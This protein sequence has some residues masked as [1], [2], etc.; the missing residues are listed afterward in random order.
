MNFDFE[1]R[2]RDTVS[3]ISKNF[4]EEIDLQSILFLIGLQELNLR[5]DKLSKDQKIEVIHVAICTLLEPYGY[6]ES[7]GLDNEGW[8]HFESKKKIPNVNKQEQE[9]IIKEAIID[10][11]S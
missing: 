7:K 3:T 8:P 11:F 2:W 4:G 1:K 9:Q 6:Y 10:Y 5:V